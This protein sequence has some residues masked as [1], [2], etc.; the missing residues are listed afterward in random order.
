MENTGNASRIYAAVGGVNGV[1]LGGG[2]TGR[3]HQER[4]NS[5]YDSSSLEL[6]IRSYAA[7][8]EREQ[9]EK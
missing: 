4:K 8:A 7:V 6:L 9:S 2:N 1:D 5:R 3:C